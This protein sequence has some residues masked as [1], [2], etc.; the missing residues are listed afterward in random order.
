M[1]D[2]LQPMTVGCQTPLSMEFFRQEHWSGF[3][4]LSP[5][6]L[7]DPG[8]ESG[9]PTLRVD[10]LLSELPGKFPSSKI[11]FRTYKKMDGEKYSLWKIVTNYIFLMRDLNP[12]YIKNSYNSNKR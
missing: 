9:S 8:T 2:S 4:F 1:S 5:E 10:S 12:E 3:P 11:L 7:P 6:D